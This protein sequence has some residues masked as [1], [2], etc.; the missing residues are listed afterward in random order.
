[1]HTRASTTSPIETKVAAP[2][3][4][5]AVFIGLVTAGYA[6]ADEH[7][8][9]L[10]AGQEQAWGGLGLALIPLLVFAVGYWSPHTPRPDVPHQHE[11]AASEPPATQAVLDAGHA[12]PDSP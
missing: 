3:L 7:F 11:G 5:V 1:M 8:L 6:V 12:V 9:N 4:S 10:T 2:S